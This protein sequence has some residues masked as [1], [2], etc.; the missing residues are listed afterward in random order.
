MRRSRPRTASRRRS[1]STAIRRCARRSCVVSRR[2]SPVERLR[3]AQEQ[4][5]GVRGAAWIDAVFGAVANI[6]NTRAQL[7]AADVEAAV[8]AIVGARRVLILGAGSSAFLTGLMEHGL[9]VCH[10][11]VQSLAL[12][13]GPSHAARR[14]GRLARSRDR[15][16][17]SALREGH[18]RTG[19]SRGA[20]CARAGHLRR[21][22]IAACADRV[23]E[24]VRQGRARFAATSEAPCSR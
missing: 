9:S 23:A 1:V 5:S 19:P 17:V 6:E 8:E 12:L 2:R 15:A 14:H 21:P 16:R 7:D 22:A 18:H 10:D 11:N 24:P 20:R 3:S 13:G 4:E